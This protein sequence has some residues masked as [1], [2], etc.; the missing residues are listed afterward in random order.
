VTSPEPAVTPPSPVA[1]PEIARLWPRFGAFVY[2]ALL[3]VGI[4]FAASWIFYAFVGDA[5]QGALKLVHRAYLLIVFG[6]YFVYCW[7]RS[8]QT[9]AMKTWGL[10][11]QRTDGH[12]LGLAVAIG[13]Y[14]LA[15][16]GLGLAGAGFLWALVDPDRQ[17]LHDRLMG[18]RVLRAPI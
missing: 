12:D 7:R 5:T 3:L 11:L 8:G 9:L 10:R 1:N 16:A 4:A 17:F 2:D 14:L 13:R 15:I 18:T 6:T